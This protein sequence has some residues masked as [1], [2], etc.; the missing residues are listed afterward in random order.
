VVIDFI[1]SHNI[2]EPFTEQVTMLAGVDQKE[3]AIPE[4]IIDGSKEKP[5]ISFALKFNND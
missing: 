3:V 4:M 1:E 2:T 5:Y